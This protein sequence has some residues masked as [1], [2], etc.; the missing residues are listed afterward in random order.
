MKRWFALALATVAVAGCSYFTSPSSS[1]SKSG[2]AS[3]PGDPGAVTFRVNE[4][5]SKHF[6][7]TVE[8]LDP[9]AGTTVSQQT[10]LGQQ[11]PFSAQQNLSALPARVRMTVTLAPDAVGVIQSVA[12]PVQA[13]YNVAPY[14]DLFAIPG[15][16]F[17]NPPT[18]SAFI[19]NTTTGNSATVVRGTLPNWITID[20]DTIFAPTD[21]YA[22]Y[23]GN[24]GMEIAW[25]NLGETSWV[26]YQTG[27]LTYTVQV[28]L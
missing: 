17:D 20:K 18:I 3:T 22:L 5:L 1:S 21:P 19:V 8:V 7:V 25:S 24:V 14:Q 27:L 13:P 4:C 23:Y 15:D 12:F 6:D 28:D 10:Y 2:A 9:V 16:S 26:D 11:A